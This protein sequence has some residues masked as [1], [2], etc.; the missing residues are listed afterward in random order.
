MHEESSCDAAD[1]VDFHHGVRGVAESGGRAV[2]V[3]RSASPGSATLNE[4]QI[5]E[6]GGACWTYLAAE[7]NT[8][9]GA[10]DHGVQYLDFNVA[11]ISGRRIGV[12]A[13]ELLDYCIEDSGSDSPGHSWRDDDLIAIGPDN[14][15]KIVHHRF[16]K[17]DTRVT[18]GR[19][20]RDF[21][22]K[23]ARICFWGRDT[24]SYAE[25]LI[26]RDCEH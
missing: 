11:C 10:I 24:D 20:C 6:Q 3:E 13:K 7:S 25:I 14:Q 8:G 2:H 18:K 23:L 12:I 15:H 9:D 16:T 26:L 22:N 5:W 4:G 17:G 19:G 1:W 21:H